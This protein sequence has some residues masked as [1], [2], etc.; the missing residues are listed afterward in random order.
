MTSAQLN[1]R[2]GRE[3]ALEMQMQLGFGE[4]TDERGD[5]VHL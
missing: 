4:T 1:Q 5:V 3:G 2:G